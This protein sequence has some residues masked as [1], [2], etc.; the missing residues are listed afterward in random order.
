MILCIYIFV[1]VPERN[2]LRSKRGL[3]YNGNISISSTGQRCFDWYHSIDAP[4]GFGGMESLSTDMNFCRVVFPARE[5][6]PYCVTHSTVTKNIVHVTC[7][8]GQKCGIQSPQD[9]YGYCD[10]PYCDGKLYDY[11]LRLFFFFAW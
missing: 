11:V 5:V 7:D 4:K 2:C 8:V 10:I 1:N 3:E 6:K 9:T